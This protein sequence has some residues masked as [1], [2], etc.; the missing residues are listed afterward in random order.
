MVGKLYKHEFK[1]WLRVM[2]VIYGITLAVAVMLRVAQ[3]FES[4]SIYYNIIFGSGVAMY[5]I[6]LLV[7]FA[8]PVF[9][10][11]VRFYQNLFTGEGYLTFTLPAT[12]AN[13]LGVKVTTAVAFSILSVIVCVVSV[14]IVTAGEVFTE[15][16]KAADYLIKLIPQDISA[17]L[18]GY[19]VEFMLL[20][21]VGFFA[22]HLLLDTCV[23][24]GQLFRKNRVLAAVGVYFGIY[25]ITQVLSTIFSV[26]MVVLEE[27]GTLEPLYAFIAEKPYET[28]HMVLCGLIVLLAALGLIYY[29]VCHWIICK[30]LNLE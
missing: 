19:C 14:M 18:T 6:A 26:G 11:T 17:H 15:L 10:G 3:I 28:A 5:I 2:S 12:P 25:M 13:H 22:E 16:Y 30:K 24:I 21:L 23:C 4:D 1:A 8:A 9:F 20:L 7:S 29:L 27:T